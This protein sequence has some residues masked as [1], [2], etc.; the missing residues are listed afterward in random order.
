M[1]ATRYISRFLL[2]FVLIAGWLFSGWPRIWN[3]PPEVQRV[4]AAPIAQY[5]G[6]L[7]VYADTVTVG[8]P[9]YKVFDD[10]TGFGVEQSATSVGAAAIQWIRV[11]ASPTNDE[12]IIAT[13]DVNND[14]KAQVCT[15]VDGGVS[16]GSPTTI[17]LTSGTSGFRNFDVAY[18]QTSGDA[19]LVY[20]TATVDELRSIVWTGGAWG[21]DAAITTTR[22]AG[23]VEWVELTSRD[24]SDQIGIAYSDTADDVSAYR[25]SGTAVGDEATA[26]I[27]ATAV[28]DNVRKFDVSFEQASGDMVVGAPV[29]AASTIAYGQLSGITWSFVSG[30]GVDV[31]T[32]F[33]DMPEPGA[34][35]VNN[36]IAVEA[37]GALAAS[38]LTEGSE[39]NGTGVTDGAAGDDPGAN[40][41]ANYQLGAVAY[42][43]TTYYGVTVFSS[44]AVPDDI[45][46]WTMDSAG[47]IT[48]QA[49]NARTRGAARFIDLFDYPNAD[50]VLLITADANSDLWAD[51][52]AGAAVTSTAWT[53]LTSGGAFLENSLASA[54]TDVVDFAFRLTPVVV[55][56]TPAYD[57]G[58]A[59][60]NNDVSVTITVASPASSTICYTTNGDTPAA[61]TPGTCSTGTTYS[62]AVSITATGTVLKAIGTKSGY[63]NS[64]VQSAT[65]T[66]QVANPSFG[67]NGGSFNNDTTSTQT[68]TTTGAVFCQTVDGTTNPE[69]STPG[70]CSVG[71]TGANATVIATGKTIKVLGTKANYVNSAVQT[72]NTFTLTVGAITSSPGAG[73]YSSTQSVTLN[74]ATTTGATAHYTTNGDAV[75]CSSTTYSGAFNI[76]TTKTVKAIGCKTNYV[77]SAAISDLYTI[78]LSTA[79]EVR[80]QNYTSSVSSITFPAGAAGATVSA[81][82][83]NINGSGSPQTFGGAGVAKPVVTL[84]NGNASSLI[85]WYNITTFTN[86]IVSSEN[87]LVNAKGAA[88]ADASC[89]TGAATFGAD[90]TTGTTILSGAGNEKDF[91]LKT[92]L[93]SVAGKTGTSTLTILGEG[94]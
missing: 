73:T 90:T 47:A 28:A 4:H 70:T 11:A 49:V 32:A 7:L 78:N 60:Y 1:K 42:L 84:Y 75:T 62:G 88:C 87:Y 15:G 21:S 72:S 3:F 5:T 65:Y 56:D 76:S 85:I 64:E 54:T 91:Y 12:W 18:E 69:A 63:A 58:T 74:I 31:V 44:A 8:T 83:N 57:N 24:S 16:C 77:S 43:S 20:G 23:A 52:W 68:S 29:A 41:A 79:I 67:T 26:V 17:T 13:L 93:S 35:T 45:D 27:T 39:W 37:I 71:T 53:D 86:S 36:D 94:V 38:N 80:A 19:L 50:K 59:T 33:L 14:I 82:Y 10:T 46:W 51:T 2:V 92:T 89:I 34:D 25:W 48:D 55:V 66:L 61:T 81:P 22:T 9:K 40:W 6:G 30:T